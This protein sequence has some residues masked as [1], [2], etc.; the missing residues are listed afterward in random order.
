M[1]RPFILLLQ[2]YLFRQLLF[3]LVVVT[4]FLVA[5]IWLTQSLRFVEVV[6][7]RGLSLGVFLELSGLL[8]PG[9]LAVILPITC[10][11][12]VQFIYLRLAN[13]RELT[14]M[15]AAGVSPLA[16]ATPALALAGL[17]VVIGYGLTLDVVPRSQAIF[18]EFQFEIRNRLAAFLLQEGVFT[19]VMDNLVVYVR[20]RSA[21]GALRG[22]MVD[23]ARDPQHHVTV[24]AESGRLEVGNAAPRVVLMRGSREEIDAHTG[25]LDVV[26]FQSS[27]IDLSQPD[28]NE[29][30]RLRDIGEMSLTEL[31]DPRPG[32]IN[33]SEYPRMRVEANKRL[34]GPLSTLSFVM[35]ALVSVLTGPFRR[36]GG[37]VRPLAAIAAVVG[38]VAVELAI[39][40]LAVRHPALIGLLWLQ[41]LAPAM[42][43]AAWLFISPGSAEEP[44]SVVEAA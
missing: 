17:A 40:S 2:R 27:A 15:R 37:V 16:L 39:E 42:I 12:T 31:L 19:P 33:P 13:D 44:P 38:L 41:A 25:Q 28:H 36:H 4:G 9:F 5:L 24:F 32:V 7:N 20:D 34:T 3:G 11:M 29:A 8:I 23:D 26:T 10:F 22:I 30:P 43:C 35:I 14:V 21:D 6:V 1:V 18:R